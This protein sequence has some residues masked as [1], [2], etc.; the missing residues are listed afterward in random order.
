MNGNISPVQKSDF[1]NVKLRNDLTKRIP[2][3][4]AAFVADGADLSGRA[5]CCPLAGYRN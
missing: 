4:C 2:E 5:D 3:A 1:Q